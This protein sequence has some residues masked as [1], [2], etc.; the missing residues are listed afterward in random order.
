MQKLA[1]LTRACRPTVA[2]LL[3]VFVVNG[4]C[5][6]RA[7]YLCLDC[8]KNVDKNWDMNVSIIIYKLHVE[9]YLV[10]LNSS[11]NEALLCKILGALATYHSLAVSRYNIIAIV[12]LQ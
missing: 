10:T 12:Q 7:I 5:V 4:A 6:R 8:T 9:Y 3:F 11:K 1:V 2:G